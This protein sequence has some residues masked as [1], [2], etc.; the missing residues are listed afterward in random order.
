MPISMC[1]L[2]VSCTIVNCW[3]QSPCLRTHSNTLYLFVRLVISTRGTVLQTTPSGCPLSCSSVCAGLVCA[4]VSTAH[5]LLV[6]ASGADNTCSLLDCFPVA[7]AHSRFRRCPMEP[8]WFRVEG[9]PALVRPLD[10]LKPCLLQIRA[11]HI[12]I[13]LDVT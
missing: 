2:H 7:Y 13:F 5:V 6:G 3:S 11:W 10:A 9:A 12:L 1:V 8:S 4:T